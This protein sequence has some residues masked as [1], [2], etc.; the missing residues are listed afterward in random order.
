MYYEIFHDYAKKLSDCSADIIASFINFVLAHTDFPE[1][2]EIALYII[3]WELERR[4]I[5]ETQATGHIIVQKN[6]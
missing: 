4:D 6:S 3:K 1:D 5:N 2:R